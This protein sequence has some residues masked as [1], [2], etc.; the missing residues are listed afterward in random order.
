MTKHA[1]PKP[2][3][4]ADRGGG[5]KPANLAAASAELGE[6]SSLEE[7]M[8]FFVSLGAVVDECLP[9]DVL[10][11][12]LGPEFT[13]AKM[14]WRRPFF[15][16][17][18]CLTSAG[19]SLDATLK[20]AR[21]V[22]AVFPAAEMVD[23]RSLS[24][25]LIAVLDELAVD[26]VLSEREVEE[27]LGSLSPAPAVT[28]TATMSAVW[29]EAE[30]FEVLRDPDHVHLRA[31][32]G[33]ILAFNRRT[34]V[35]NGFQVVEEGQCFNCLVVLKFGVILRAERMLRQGEVDGGAS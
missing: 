6:G 7:P 35:W 23:V 25:N 3:V 12:R 2:D 15:L 31:S 26:G 9:R 27:S 20:V 28:A 32:D 30:V 14:Y 5:M 13:N 4:P 11:K 19:S 17:V 34:S 18:E 16:A 1:R 22:R 21:D 10:L 8:E 29:I 33:R 24:G